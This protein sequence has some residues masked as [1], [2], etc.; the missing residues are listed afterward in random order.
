LL[1]ILV[2]LN[3]VVLSVSLF[4]SRAAPFLPHSPWTL[5]ARSVIA[6]QKFVESSVAVG[7]VKRVQ[8][9]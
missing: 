1:Y 6:S 8:G 4:L 2:V 7:V 5:D 9:L 3:S